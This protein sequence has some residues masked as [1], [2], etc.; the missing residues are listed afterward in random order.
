MSC[1]HERT[2]LVSGECVDCGMTARSIANALRA[3]NARLTREL[4][5]ARDGIVLRGWWCDAQVTCG[6]GG[7]MGPC[8]TFNG[9]EHS[10]RTEC[11]RCGAPKPA[12]PERRA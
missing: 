9:I 12:V 3:E 4:A 1:R 11:R 8:G 6:T 7:A 5:E 2:S 10:P